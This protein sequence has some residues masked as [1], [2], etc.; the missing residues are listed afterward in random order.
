MT[1]TL[2]TPSMLDDVTCHCFQ[3]WLVLVVVDIFYP[4]FPGLEVTCSVRF[5]QADDLLSLVA[6][7]RD[8]VRSLKSIIES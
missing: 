5:D 6:E 4:Q 2:R 8:E 3:V 7:L 1:T